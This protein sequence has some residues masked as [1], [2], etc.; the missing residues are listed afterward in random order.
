MIVTIPRI[1][2]GHRNSHLLNA[3]LCNS[4]LSVFIL[5]KTFNVPMLGLGDTPMNKTQLQILKEFIDL[6]GRN[7]FRYK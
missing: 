7:D 5:P 1:R 2:K 6:R 3:T 4:L